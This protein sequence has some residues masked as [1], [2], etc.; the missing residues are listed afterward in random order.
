ML[1][2]L[3]QHHVG[4]LVSS[5]EDFKSE[6]REVWT[7]DKYSDTYFISSQDVKVC[8]LQNCKDTRIELVEPGV[9]NKTLGKLLSKGFSFYHVGFISHTYENS[10]EHLIQSNCRQLSEFH[11]EA[12][13]GKRCT[14]FYHP[15][16]KLIELIEGD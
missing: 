9:H 8:F 10:V 7:E 1:P 12:F 16:L 6:N 11:S 15:Q 3:D 4:I 5:I 14:F 13:N 2:E